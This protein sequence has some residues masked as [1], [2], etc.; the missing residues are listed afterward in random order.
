M[1]KPEFAALRKFNKTWAIDK[2]KNIHLFFSSSDEK[3]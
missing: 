1:I 3:G 2:I